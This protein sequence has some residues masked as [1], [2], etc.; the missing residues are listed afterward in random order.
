MDILA[1]RRSVNH[2][3]HVITNTNLFVE[4]TQGDFWH[5]FDKAIAQLEA[6]ANSAQ[7]QLEDASRGM[8]SFIKQKFSNDQDLLT[9]HAARMRTAGANVRF[10]KDGCV[11]ALKLDRDNPKFRLL[12]LQAFGYLRAEIEATKHLIV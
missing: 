2:E 3:K 9:N 11:P 8:H 10:L 12:A 6:F 4:M 7:A 1:A 5:N